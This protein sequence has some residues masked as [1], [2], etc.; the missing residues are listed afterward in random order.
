MPPEG[1]LLLPGAPGYYFLSGSTGGI[2]S[3]P[4]FSPVLPHLCYD[5]IFLERPSLAPLPLPA[6][7]PMRFTRA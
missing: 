1:R 5:V 3:F 7:C 4:P 2:G 6:L